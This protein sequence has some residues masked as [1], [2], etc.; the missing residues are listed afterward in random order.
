MAPC[1]TLQTR[2]R[3][4]NQGTKAVGRYRRWIII[5]AF[6]EE[7]TIGA[8]VEHCR[9]LGDFAVVVVDDASSDST[10]RQALLHGARVL[11]LPIRLGAWGA[12]QTGLRYAVCHGCEV[13]VTLDGDG[14][15]DPRDIPRLLEPLYK[16]TADL[17]IGSCPERGSHARRAAWTLFRFLTDLP[18]LDLTSGYR[19]YNRKT[20]CLLASR[21]ATL[22]DYQDIGVL[23]LAQSAGL[24]I[25]EVP[26]KM[27][28]RRNG[29][30]RVFQNWGAVL[31]YLLYSGCIGISKR[32]YFPKREMK[33]CPPPPNRGAQ[34]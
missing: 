32:V 17:V 13:A 5:P 15:H 27:A 28:P 24:R 11:P 26:V 3:E 8:V 4:G 19:A 16:G 10:R 21:Q 6:N 23:L 22:L 20:A 30:S 12:T 1:G 33:S 31:W 9:A 2:H 14:Q 34:S 18:V 7:E 29:I 25:R